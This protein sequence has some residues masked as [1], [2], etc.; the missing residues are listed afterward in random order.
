MR[1]FL[2]VYWN[3]PASLSLG[4]TYPRKRL[5]TIHLGLPDRDA[6]GPSGSSVRGIMARPSPLAFWASSPYPSIMRGLDYGR[7]LRMR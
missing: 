5:D 3:I 1:F 4:I 7:Q 6:A 2:V